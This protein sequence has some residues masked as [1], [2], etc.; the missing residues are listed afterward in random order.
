MNIGKLAVPIGAAAL[1]AGIAAGG[2]V[3]ASAVN[4]IK[5]FGTQE[6]LVDGANEIGYTVAGLAPSADTILY[7][8][9]GQLYE[10]TV[11]V[12]AVRGWVTPMVPFFNARSENG[13][14][15]RVLANV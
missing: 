14:N 9:N 10:S 1:I 5:L 13:A 15:Y 7:E 2:A 12:E 6:T 11:T 8:I 4:N 3:P